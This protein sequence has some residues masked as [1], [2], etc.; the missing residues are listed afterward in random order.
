[1]PE[2]GQRTERARARGQREAFAEQGNAT[3]VLDQRLRNQA[4]VGALNRASDPSRPRSGSGLRN[5]EGLAIWTVYG[6]PADI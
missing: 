6:I 2:T 5:S 1:V 4:T 3:Q